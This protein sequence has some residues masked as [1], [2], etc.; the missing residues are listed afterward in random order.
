MPKSS[1]EKTVESGISFL[2]KIFPL[3]SYLYFPLLNASLF[4]AIKRTKEW[5]E[6]IFSWKVWLDPE[7]VKLKPDDFILSFFSDNRALMRCFEPEIRKKDMASLRGSFARLYPILGLE[8][9]FLSALFHEEMESGDYRKIVK[10][11]DQKVI[12]AEK[13]ISELKNQSKLIR[14]LKD[15]AGEMV[16]LSLE[17]ISQEKVQKVIAEIIK[18]HVRSKNG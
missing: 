11:F 15:F 7:R 13:D 1:L 2:S 6:K 17:L 8:D 12:Q 4:W 10:E 18:K 3:Q 14:G 5:K 16:S 9:P